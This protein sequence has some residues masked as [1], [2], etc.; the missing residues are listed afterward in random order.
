M[1]ADDILVNFMST[2]F[3]HVLTV[4][5]LGRG[6]KVGGGLDL[7]PPV[8][9]LSKL[10]CDMKHWIFKEKLTFL[11]NWSN[12]WPDHEAS[13]DKCL[14]HTQQLVM[15]TV[16]R[17]QQPFLVA[18]ALFWAMTC[19]TSRKWVR[20]TSAW[21]L[22]QLLRKPWRHQTSVYIT[23][24]LHHKTQARS[25]HFSG[26]WVTSFSRPLQPF[27]EMF[28]TEWLNLCHLCH[29]VAQAVT[30]SHTPILTTW[31]V[32]HTDL[33]REVFFLWSFRFLG[34]SIFTGGRPKRCTWVPRLMN[35]DLSLSLSFCSL[36]IERKNCK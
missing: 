14:D 25:Q 7:N 32:S 12:G 27:K 26:K 6:L 1:L 21:S 13:H 31:V 8:C 15:T 36:L 16:W 34:I 11:R 10:L 19:V 28:A 24:L 4:G 29:W 35:R 33:G 30:R 17:R 9:L 18:R 3:S 2:T 22:K 23:W 20:S 5:D